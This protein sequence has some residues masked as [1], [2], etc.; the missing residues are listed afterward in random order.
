MP[1]IVIRSWHDNEH[2]LQRLVPRERPDTRQTLKKIERS[3]EPFMRPIE[4]NAMRQGRLRGLPIPSVPK[5][6]VVW[7]MREIRKRISQPTENGARKIKSITMLIM[8]DIEPNVV[9]KPVL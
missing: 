5:N 1:R 4:K 8:R 2:G 3:I 6:C 9:R 7:H